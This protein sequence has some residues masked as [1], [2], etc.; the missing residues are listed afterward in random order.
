MKKFLFFLLLFAMHTSAEVSSSLD[1]DVQRDFDRAKKLSVDG[2]EE[3]AKISWMDFLRRYP[4]HGLSDNAHFHLGEIYQR[5][6]LFEQAILEFRKVFSDKRSDMRPQAAL[7]MGNCL[8][9][10]NNPRE[11]K[12]QWAAIVRVYPK[13]SAAAQAKLRL[14]EL[15]KE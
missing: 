14:L 2:F 8:K 7:E 11:A 3:K 15:E 4:S 1:T 9:K 5:Q 12:I 6:E 10:M 13:S